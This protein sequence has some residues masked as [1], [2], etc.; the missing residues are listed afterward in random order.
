MVDIDPNNY[1]HQQVYK[2]FTATAVPRPIAWVSTVSA[3]GQPNLAPF[4]FFTPV[5]SKP[6]TLAFCPGI[7]A[8]TGAPKDT[9]NN[10]K[11]S[12]EFVVNFVTEA[13]VEQMNI[14]ATEL[15]PHVN[16]FERAG[17]TP[18]PGRTV[19]V[20]HVAETPA[21]FECRV[22][23]IVTVSEDIGG[24]YIVVGTVLLMHFDESIYR[25]NNYI[26]LAAFQP[27]GRLTGA[28]YCRVTDTFD[29]ERLPPEIIPVSPV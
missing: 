14:S 4:S 29:L 15:P 26:D 10:L 8:G 13:L 12:G 5:C 7:R 28:G 18:A 1:P 23:E 20:P 22:R 21:Y 9:Y 11:V 3:D 16:E 17:L 25:D 6:P 19:S 2:L 27:V 24:G